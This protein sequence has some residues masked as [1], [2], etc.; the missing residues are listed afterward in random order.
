MEKI[1]SSG[2]VLLISLSPYLIP[3]DG[4]IRPF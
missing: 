3:L 1:V 4:W 2:V